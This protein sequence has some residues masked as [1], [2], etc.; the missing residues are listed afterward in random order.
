MFKFRHFTFFYFIVTFLISTTAFSDDKTGW[1]NSRRYMSKGICDS[2]YKDMCDGKGVCD[3]GG[4]VSKC[5]TGCGQIPGG[6]YTFSYYCSPPPADVCTGNTVTKNYNYP[7]QSCDVYCVGWS[8]HYCFILDGTFKQCTYGNDPGYCMCGE[9]I[10]T[11][12]G[13]TPIP[14]N[15]G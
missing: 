15:G 2:N 10:G 1:N 14:P 7:N 12:P 5:N 9:I 8:V 6:W 4:P 13:C 3:T 11:T